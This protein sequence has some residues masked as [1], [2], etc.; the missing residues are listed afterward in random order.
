MT[1][2]NNEILIKGSAQMDNKKAV[3]VLAELRE[4]LETQHDKA[5]AV[6]ERY[7]EADEENDP[8]LQKLLAE[9]G[10]DEEI[11]EAVETISAENYRQ[12]RFWHGT[13]NG[14]RFARDKL[15]ELSHKP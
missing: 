12:C 2:Y 6:R 11:C 8:R 7:A 9:G 14:F 1:N 15:F 5:W 10:S 13:A 3:Q 4:W